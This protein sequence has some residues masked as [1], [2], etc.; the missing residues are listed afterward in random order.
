[1]EISTISPGPTGVSHGGDPSQEIGADIVQSSDVGS[2]SGTESLRFHSNQDFVSL[3][4]NSGLN[5][6]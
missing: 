1:M 4:Q 2:H 3:V 6:S 5:G